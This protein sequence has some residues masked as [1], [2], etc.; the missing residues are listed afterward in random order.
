MSCPQRLQIEKGENMTV[1]CNPEDIQLSSSFWYKGDPSVSGPVLRLERGVPGGTEYGKRHYDITSTGAM[2]IIDATVDHE[3]I[4]SFLAYFDDGQFEKLNVTLVVTITP[5]Q[6][7]PVIDKCDP[8]KDCKKKVNGTDSLRCTVS[9]SRPKMTLNWLLISANGIKIFR[10]RKTEEKDYSTDSWNTSSVLPYV[11]RSCNQ[12]AVLQCVAQDEMRLLK[13]W[14]S[15]VNIYTGND[16]NT[17]I[18]L[19]MVLALKIC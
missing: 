9:H 1:S 8:C 5:L 12:Q 13:H 16:H 6:A 18:L 14:H 19:Q 11:A 7:C 10:P 3:G 4:Y 17:R 15:S 2:I